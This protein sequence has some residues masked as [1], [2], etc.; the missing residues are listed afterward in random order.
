[1]SLL[2]A[3]LGPQRGK[4]GMAVRAKH[5]RLAVDQGVVDGQ[6]AHRLGNRSQSIGE[7]GSV[8]APQAHAIAVLAG[9]QFDNPSCFTSCAQPGPAGGWATRVGRQG[10]M[11]PAGGERRERAGEMRHCMP[12]M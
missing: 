9:E 12:A 3:R 11:K 1:M 5:H 6:G 10:W 8:P 4:V 2:A 7:V